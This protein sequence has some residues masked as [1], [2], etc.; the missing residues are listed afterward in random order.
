MP[1]FAEKIYI[2]HVVLRSLSHFLQCF[3]RGNIARERSNYP[4][5]DERPPI[6][7]SKL[8]AKSDILAW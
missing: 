7:S 2:S 8:H 6:V 1:A 5:T 3:G 4:R